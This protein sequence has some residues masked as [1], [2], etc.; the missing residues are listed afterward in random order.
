MSLKKSLSLLTLVTT[1][2]LVGIGV[3][4]TFFSDTET[5]VGNK[6]VAGKF[7]LMVDNTCEYNGQVCT[8]GKWGGTDESCSCTWEKKDL[9]GDL[10]FNL[11][12]V[13]PGDYGEDTI[14]LHVNNNDAWMCAEVANL[15]SDDNGC[16]PPETAAGDTTCGAGGGE[17]KDNL[18]FTVWKDINC[19]NILDTETIAG[20]CVGNTPQFEESCSTQPEEICKT[21]SPP[22]EPQNLL[23]RWVDGQSAEPVLVS[24]KPARA[25]FW[26][27]ADATT[28][29]GPLSG[30]KDYCLGVSWKV[31]LATSNIIQ[32]DS[33]VGDVKFKAVQSRHMDNFKCSDI[34]TEV[35][36]GIDNNFNGQTD[37][38]PLWTNKG[39]SCSVG[40]G[41]CQSTGTYICDPVNSAGP[42]ICSVT[43][44]VP[45]A[46]VC[47]G[48]DDN[49]NGVV[50]E[51][52]PG[53]GGACQMKGLLGVC[54]AGTLHCQN[55]AV[56]CTQNVQS[57]PEVC[58][59]Q[60]N[61]CD[62]QVDEGNPGGGAACNTGKPGICAVGTTQCQGGALNCTQNVS[63]SPEVCNGLDDNCNGIVDEGNPGGGTACST[64]K[65]GICNAGTIQCSGGTLACTENILPSAEVCDGLDN[66]CYGSVD[67]GVKNTY[68]RDADSD[69]YGNPSVTTQ[70][71]IAPAGY[72]SNSTDCNDN[73]AA[74]HPG[75][76]EVC[77]G[78]DDNCDGQVDGAGTYCAGLNNGT[79]ACIA[80]VCTLASCLAGYGNCD[81]NPANGCEVNLTNNANNCGTCNA[82]CSLNHGVPSC[83]AGACI[84]SCNVHYADCNSNPR[85]DGCETNLTNDNYNCGTCAH[86][87]AGGQSCIASVCT[88]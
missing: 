41:A 58:D 60:D 19:N 9:A 11:P 8:D 57:S 15:I 50:D 73:N 23:C 40:V 76:T 18:L 55:G 39:Q 86:A 34:Y 1:V 80:G 42:T 74:I 51:D 53:G 78:I 26:P 32:G 4:R 49:C 12:D 69:G 88:P 75:A 38:G 16:E 79:P 6:F 52:D 22:G 5:S 59:G 27:I 25:G 14:S 81:N 28:G 64:G 62:G 30:G 46:E 67:E 31:P 13:K 44:G 17:L 77:N 68:Y 72:V 7:N 82:P 3:T 70:A 87:C 84:I 43:A 48:I 47:N 20:H 56:Q 37:E 21:A 65:P 33:L 2:V 36:D 61:N 83:I 85:S 35:C 54:S 66:N 63:S 71:C 10:F 24:D 45:G 29:T